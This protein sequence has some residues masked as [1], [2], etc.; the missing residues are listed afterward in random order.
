MSES[1]HDRLV[2]LE[3]S[4]KMSQQIYRETLA[5]IKTELRAQRE[6]LDNGLSKR[7]ANE[8]KNK[9]TPT[10][11]KEKA[12]QAAHNTKE[13][14]IKISVFLIV[15][16]MVAQSFGIDIDITGLLP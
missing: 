13:W 12:L 16:K 4:C 5:D 9:V 11:A 1:D 6:F 14:T 7:I 15:L 10:N 8:L 2:K 3:T